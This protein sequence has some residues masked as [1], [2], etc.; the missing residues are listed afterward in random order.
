MGLLAVHQCSGPR[1]WQVH[2]MNSIVQLANQI[3]YALDQAQI[4]Q[5]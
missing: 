5:Q 4:L 3:G 2:E 1:T